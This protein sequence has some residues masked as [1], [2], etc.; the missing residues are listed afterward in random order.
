[1]SA[2]Q[3]DR[4]CLCGCGQIVNIPRRKD[5]YR[6][7]KRHAPVR[8]YASRACSLKVARLA[9]ATTIAQSARLAPDT[10]WE[11]A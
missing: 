6:R 10:E 7:S 2:G 5:G 8:H 11:A 3:L 1:M 9:R 4:P